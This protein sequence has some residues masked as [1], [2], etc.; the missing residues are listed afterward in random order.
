L[1]I[2]ELNLA[3]SM[4][5]GDSRPDHDDRDLHVVHHNQDDQDGRSRASHRTSPSLSSSRKCSRS[6]SGSLSFRSA[7]SS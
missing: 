2:D 6:K 1:L 5:S 4:A 3:S 7:S